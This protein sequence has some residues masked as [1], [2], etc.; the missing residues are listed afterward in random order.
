MPDAALP[1]SV[2]A[3]VAP[4]CAGGVRAAAPSVRTHAGGVTGRYG[5]FPFCAPEMIHGTPIDRR[6]DPHALR[7]VHEDSS[8]ADT[9]RELHAEWQRLRSEL[10]VPAQDDPASVSSKQGPAGRKRG[11]AKK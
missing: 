5:L 4:P 1:L 7:N 8:A 9:R 11:P 6:R 2:I 10:K 3:T